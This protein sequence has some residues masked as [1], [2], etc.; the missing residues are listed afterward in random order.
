VAEGAGPADLAIAA[1]ARTV[2][3][4]V[5]GA[6]APSTAVREGRVKIEG[7]VEAL[8]VFPALFEV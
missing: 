7:D 3:G 1:D 8:A 5:S 2:L 6:L 4:L